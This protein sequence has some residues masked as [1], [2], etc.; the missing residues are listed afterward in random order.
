MGSNKQACR[1]YRTEI[2]SVLERRHLAQKWAEVRQLLQ[3][4]TP[5]RLLHITI[6]TLIS[7]SS[8]VSNWSQSGT[9]SDCPG[10]T[11]TRKWCG[12]SLSQLGPFT[13]HCR[14]LICSRLAPCAYTVLKQVH[15]VIIYFMKSPPFFSGLNISQKWIIKTALG[16]TSLYSI[17]VLYTYICNLVNRNGHVTISQIPDSWRKLYKIPRT[18]WPL[19]FAL[20]DWKI[21]AVG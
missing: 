5:R 20:F 7:A 6:S 12:W 14:T 13:G 21:Q 4:E 3:K 19:P 17:S 15:Q 8:T 11:A 2:G 1:V 16:N 18:I 9:V 10:K